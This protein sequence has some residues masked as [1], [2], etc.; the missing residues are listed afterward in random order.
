[1]NCEHTF[2]GVFDLSVFPKDGMGLPVIA[3]PTPE[4]FDRPLDVRCSRCGEEAPPKR[5]GLVRSKGK[6]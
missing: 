5:A 4:D 3:L 6:A 2:V 1:M